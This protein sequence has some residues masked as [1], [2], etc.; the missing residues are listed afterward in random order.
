MP[1]EARIV[2]AVP[3][4]GLCC[5]C[6]ADAH[7]ARSSVPQLKGRVSCR[8]QHVHAV[9]RGSL[10]A[11]RM[12]GWTSTDRV[13]AQCLL[14]AGSTSTSQLRLRKYTCGVYRSPALFPGSGRA[15]GCRKVCLLSCRKVCLYARSVARPRPLL[16]LAQYARGVFKPPARLRSSA[17]CP[18]TPRAECCAL[19]CQGRAPGTW[20]GIP[21]EAILN[22]QA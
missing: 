2:R 8:E 9:A 4:L 6:A 17:R 5:V 20:L 1:E 15:C 19:G 11:R 13:S 14:S 16:R 18:S 3:A 10:L 21:P 22:H 7:S 12:H